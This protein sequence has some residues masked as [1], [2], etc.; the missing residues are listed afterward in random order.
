MTEFIELHDTS[1]NEQ[2]I[3]IKLSENNSINIE[4]DFNHTSIN[5]RKNNR[6][7]WLYTPDIITVNNDVIPN[8]TLRQLISILGFN[9]HIV[10]I[11]RAA[12]NCTI[13]DE[14]VYTLPLC[15]LII[16]PYIRY[17]S[18]FESGFTPFLEYA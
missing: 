6:L 2:I 17:Y 1:L 18:Q 10:T 13:L 3:Q 8:I 4:R 11:K 16:H 12:C 9:N 7:F 15:Q 5:V 14:L